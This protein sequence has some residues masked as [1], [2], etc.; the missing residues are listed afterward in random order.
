MVSVPRREPHEIRPG[1]LPAS[2]LV[3]DDTP[4]DIASLLAILSEAG[5]RVRA[6]RDADT[7]FDQ[8]RAAAPDLILLDTQMPGVN[9]FETCRRL[10][11][12][13]RLADTPVIFMTTPAEAADRV[14]A[15]AAGGDDYVS[16][17]FQYQEVLARVRLHLTRRTLA[18]ELE[19]LH[20]EFE[21]RVAARIVE[22]KTAVAEGE[23]LRN[24][25]Q[26]QNLALKEQLQKSSRPKS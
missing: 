16:R 1:S 20:R 4:A 11:Q 19:S 22:L 24:L 2:I 8:S 21:K 23:V 9:G 15:F 10:R 13:P 7:A 5:Y 6:A 14:S 17:P 18:C 26:Q 12:S 3:V 25:L